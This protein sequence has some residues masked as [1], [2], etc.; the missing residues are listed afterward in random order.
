MKK[1]RI[2]AMLIIVVL[3]IS[4]CI[5]VVAPTPPPTIVPTKIPTEKPDI[6]VDEYDV[7]FTDFDFFFAYAVSLDGY[8]GYALFDRQF[9]EEEDGLWLGIS[10]MGVNNFD[11]EANAFG[12]VG[13]SVS[14]TIK[15][16]GANFSEKPIGITLI[17]MNDYME[18]GNGMIIFWEGLELFAED[19]ITTD[20]L[21]KNYVIYMPNNEINN[22]DL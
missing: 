10:V 21:V 17:F 9:F 7:F 20:E 2:L 12:A 15:A 19:Q 11:D 5:Q 13:A 3:L 1:I 18:I 14:Q 22:S 16:G 4:G 8:Q 6:S